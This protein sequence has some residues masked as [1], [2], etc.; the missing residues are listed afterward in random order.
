MLTESWLRESDF[1]LT[2][3]KPDYISSCGLEALATLGFDRGT[4]GF[5]GGGKSGTLFIGSFTG[6]R[7]APGH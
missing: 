3:T 7:D 4:G 2:P 1:H 5:T 6:S